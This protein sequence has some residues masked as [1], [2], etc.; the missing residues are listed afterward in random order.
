MDASHKSNERNF[1]ASFLLKNNEEFYVGRMT[2]SRSLSLET[3]FTRDEY[4]EY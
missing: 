1:L 4:H 3:S 2:D